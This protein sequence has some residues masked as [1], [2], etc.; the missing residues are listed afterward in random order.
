M[1]WERRRVGPLEVPD[2]RRRCLFPYRRLQRPRL[3]PRHLE[4][5]RGA[6][7]LFVNNPS[8]KEFRRVLGNVARGKNLSATIQSHSL[9]RRQLPVLL[10]RI[11]DLSEPNEEIT[12]GDCVWPNKNARR[13]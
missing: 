11:V 8:A 6:K 4:N 5:F 12:R 2:N 7:S 9:L 3:K 1:G 13:N 10:E